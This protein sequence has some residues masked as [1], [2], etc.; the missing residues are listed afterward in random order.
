MNELTNILDQK[1]GFGHVKA[2]SVFSYLMSIVIK[3][4]SA[5]S[6]TSMQRT[7][8]S[9]KNVST[10]TSQGEAG[11]VLG[12]WVVG[13]AFLFVFSVSLGGGGVKIDFY[14]AF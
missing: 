5:R 1:H 12:V 6:S 3:S 7:L 2:C 9:R 10:S 11:V 8:E 14:Y 4:P 13:H